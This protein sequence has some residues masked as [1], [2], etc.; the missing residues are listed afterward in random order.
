MTRKPNKIKI[1]IAEFNK[2]SNQISDDWYFDEDGVLPDNIEEYPPN[3]IL[4]IETG[5]IYI[6]WQGRGIDPPNGEP[7]EKEFVNEFLK[8]KQLQTHRICVIKI[9]NE[10]FNRIKNLLKENGVELEETGDSLCTHR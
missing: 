5:T 7:D 8:W 4:T 1:T 2:F 3:T 6:V 10:E 9:K